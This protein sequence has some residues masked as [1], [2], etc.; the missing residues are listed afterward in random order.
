ML[1]NNRKDEEMRRVTIPGS[2]YARAASDDMLVFS[3]VQWSASSFERV[4]Q[5]FGNEALP[6][7][8]QILYAYSFEA[9]FV[10]PREAFL[11]LLSECLATCTGALLAH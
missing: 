5:F 11:S 9:N 7:A 1:S 2:W 4:I 8:Q 3:R 10:V 6:G